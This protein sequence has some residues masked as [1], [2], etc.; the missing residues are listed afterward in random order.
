MSVREAT[1][2][3]QSIWLTPARFAHLA[4]FLLALCVLATTARAHDPFE[5]FTSAVVRADR[6]DLIITMAQSTALKLID[7]TARIPS[8]TPENLAEHR[9]RFLREGAA[10]FVVTSVH[11]KLTAR[12]IEIELTEENDV[13]F[14]LTYPRPAPGRLLFSASYLKKLGDGYGGI[15][16]VNDD[17]DH[18]L[19]WEQLLWAQPN[20]E[21]TVPPAAPRSE[22][23]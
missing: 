16:E 8:L 14:K 9:P 7:P 19:G 21:V 12:K 5:A 20:L 3:R 1:A 17:S 4:L 15:F 6:L 23:K 2:T 18:N 13:V 11:T 10:L 22:K